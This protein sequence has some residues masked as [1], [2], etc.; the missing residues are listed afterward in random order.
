MRLS[1][2]ALLLLLCLSFGAGAQES[3]EI[4]TPEP[5]T[6]EVIGLRLPVEVQQ[7]RSSETITSD[8]MALSPSLRI[9]QILGDSAGLSLFRR[10]DSFT[11]NPTIQGINA[12]GLGGNAA[13]RV[14]VM[15][16]GM[17][18]NDPFGGWVN[19]SGLNT[20]SLDQITILRGG[21][22]GAFGSQAMGGAI[23]MESAKPEDLTIGVQAGFGSLDTKDFAVQLGDRLDGAWYQISA[24][25][26]DT[27]GPWILS[28]AD[29]GAAD[30]R[31]KSDVL[32]G[33][34]IGGIEINDD[35]SVEAS[36]RGFRDRRANGIDGADNQ[37][38]GLDASFRL[39]AKV[40][41]WD[42][43]ATAYYQKR[44]FANI[45]VAA[46][47]ERMTARPVLDQFDV[48]GRSP[49]LIIKAATQLA[50]SGRLELG[51]DV[52][53]RRGETNE[54]YRNLGSGF[55]RV[56]QAGGKQRLS[57]AYATYDWLG[58]ALSL[59]ANVR[60]NHYQY[61]RGQRTERD[62]SSGNILRDDGFSDR[63]DG[64]WTGRL[65][66]GWQSSDSL[67][68]SGALWKGYRSP[69]NNELFRPFRVGND[70]TEANGLLLPEKARGIELTAKAAL[71][72]AI[73]ATAT[74]YRIGLED[75]VGNVTIGFGP[76]FFPL[77]GFVPGGGVLRQRS[78][79][80]KSVTS[81]VE[82]R[83]DGNFDHGLEIGLSWQ[84]ADAEIKAF[85]ARPEL[86]GQRPVQTP[87]HQISG[88][89][90]WQANDSLSVGLS[91]RHSSGQF[92]DDLGQR[93]LSAFTTLDVRIAHEI[94][95]G[96]ELK[97]SATNITNTR[98]VSALSGTGLETIAR[99]RVLRL[100]FDASF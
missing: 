83:L 47:D 38:D 86:I 73:T 92:D 70:I 48:P 41:A 15:L 12:R 53:T 98:V 51:S 1:Y 42:V 72:D 84:Y 68:I 69:T 79:I 95:D 26:L 80:D 54:R 6:I 4:E 14:L 23:V 30:V 91:V 28:E 18:L 3:P 58:E 100:G 94:S 90:N 67:N 61:T 31:A 64:V 7:G 59:H 66:F 93:R 34:F 78:N 97:V 27:D 5:E 63:S 11:A 43:D 32:H 45:F 55:T 82:A 10:A 8:Q 88:R 81:G 46:R 29:R 57:G 40:G 56:R 13:G 49:G 39:L 22:F 50:D 76:G 9:D 2:S 17:P 37:T 85:A 75:G 87:K 33:R 21:G 16:D 71:S 44:D 35:L 89:L 77:G 65:A 36:L 74:L 99:P 96:L 24:G 25:W 62:L 20:R 60:Y 19:W 52:T